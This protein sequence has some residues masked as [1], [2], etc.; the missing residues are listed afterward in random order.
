M[1]YSI[2]KP[3]NENTKNSRIDNNLSKSNNNICAT[4]IDN[5]NSNQNHIDTKKIK[6][7]NKYNNRAEREKDKNFCGFLFFKFLCGKKENIF[8]I[9]NEFRIKMISEEH[10]IKN[11]LNI[12]N[13]LKVTERKRFHRRNS[14]QLKEVLNLV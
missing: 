11:H 2:E 14:Y 1:N 9:Y 3:K 12:Y 4:S 5:V 7:L 8:N 6:N 13:L 10:L